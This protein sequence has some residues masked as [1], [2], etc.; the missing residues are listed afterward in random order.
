MNR[1]GFLKLSLGLSVGLFLNPIKTISGLD[2]KS[3]NYNNKNVNRKLTKVVSI[4]RIYYPSKVAYLLTG[5]Q[6][7][8]SCEGRIL[9]LRPIRPNFL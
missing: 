3:E 6:P 2:T 7:M 1:R 5:I 8:K 4:I 9:I